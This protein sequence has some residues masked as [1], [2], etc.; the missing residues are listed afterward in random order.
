MWHYTALI[1]GSV[2]DRLSLH[3]SILLVI[4][5]DIL[6]GRHS[7]NN[8][9]NVLACLLLQSYVMCHVYISK[10]YNSTKTEI[11]Q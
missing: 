4:G 11:Y 1:V 8:S 9:L 6:E 3:C 7:G 10:L 2:V 5:L